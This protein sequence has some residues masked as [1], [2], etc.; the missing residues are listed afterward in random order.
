MID[1]LHQIVTEINLLP[2]YFGK[3]I[4]EL[5]ILIVGSIIVGWIT[6]TYFAQRAAESEVKGDIMKK[7]LDIYEAMVIK[8]EAMQ[9][10]VVLP[11]K[12]INIAVTN[13]KENEIPLKYVPQYPVLDVFQT[14]D[15]LTAAVLDIDRFISTNRIYFEK[16]LYEKLQFFSKL[17]TRFQSFDSDVSGAFYR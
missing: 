8:L 4:L 16:G 1:T 2:E 14:G 17:Y 7:K 6:S 10:Q 12:I 15:K 9:Q 11:H 5:I 13:I 3:G